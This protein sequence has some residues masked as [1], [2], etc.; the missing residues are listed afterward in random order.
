MRI[1]FKNFEVSILKYAITTAECIC[2]NFKDV[3]DTEQFV[4][5]LKKENPYIR[6]EK[7]DMW[8]LKWNRPGY[9]IGEYILLK[10]VS[11]R[12]LYIMREILMPHLKFFDVID[13]L[14]NT[15]DTIYGYVDEYKIFIVSEDGTLKEACE[16]CFEDPHMEFL[17]NKIWRH[18]TYILN[19]MNKGNK[20]F[21]YGELSSRAKDPKIDYRNIIIDSG[22]FNVSW[23]SN[24]EMIA[25][26]KSYITEMKIGDFYVGV[27]TIEEISDRLW[28]N[29]N[30]SINPQFL[31]CFKIIEED[32]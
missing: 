17:R 13:T 5:S 2:T 8:T 27:K 25:S 9:D 14:L 10:N 19:Q 29:S 7:I 21:S 22:K 4:E 24:N 12:D 18:R 28:I 31:D 23:T 1:N 6:L 11:N 30:A 3:E 15:K 16:K 32:N 26:S 20:N